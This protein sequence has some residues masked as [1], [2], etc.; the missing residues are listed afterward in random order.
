MAIKFLYIDDEPTNAKGII[1]PICDTDLEITVEPPKTWSEQKVHLIDSQGLNQYDGI[2][3][4]L[5]LEFTDKANEETKYKGSDLAQSIRTDVK[6]KKIHDLPIFLCSTQDMQSLDRTGYDLFD[7]VYYKDSFSSDSNIKVEFIDFANAYKSLRQGFDIP[8]LLNINID[9]NDDLFALQSEINKCITPHEVVYLIHKYVIQSNGILLDENLLA[10]RLGIDKERS[11]DWIKLKDE[12]LTEFKYKG[13]LSNCYSRWWQSPIL[14]WWKMTF[15]KSL[16]V[17]SSENKISALKQKF[18]M[19]DLVPITLPANHKFDSFWYKCIL[20]DFA[21]EP[22]D[23]FRTL[24]MPRYVWQEPNYISV[25]YL[26][27]DERDRHKIMSLIGKN[28][29]KFFEHMI[30]NQ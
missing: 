19:D 29:Q 2:L 5:K 12:L 15:G 3:L 11:K 23:A 4:D 20:S 17:M 26:T 24:E 30:K 21:L 6:S 8:I 9:D 18:K 1:M 7:K 27:S 16:K 28:E 13:I 25:A 14:N 10:I 22:S